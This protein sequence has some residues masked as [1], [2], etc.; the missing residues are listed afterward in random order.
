MVLLAAFD[1]LVGQTETAL[2]ETAA[3]TNADTSAMLGSGIAEAVSGAEIVK[4]I[5]SL[6]DDIEGTSDKVLATDVVIDRERQPHGLVCQLSER[7]SVNEK[8]EVRSEKHKGMERC[9]VCICESKKRAST[10]NENDG[11]PYASTY[12]N[13]IS[14]SAALFGRLLKQANCDRNVICVHTLPNRSS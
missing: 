10:E 14:R 9:M 8:V 7:A 5:A 3:C 12:F 2:H 13:I 6:A 4:S 11:C 1:V